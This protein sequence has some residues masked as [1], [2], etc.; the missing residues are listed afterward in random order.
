MRLSDQTVLEIGRGQPPGPG[1]D[2]RRIDLGDA[3]LLPRWVNAHTHLEFSG[4]SAPIGTPGIALSDWIRQVVAARAGESLAARQH[5]VARGI[6]ELRDS[7][8]RLAADIVTPPCTPPPSAAATQRELEVCLLPEVIG[9]SATRSDER[10]AAAVGLMQQYPAAG[11]SPHAPYSTR[12][13]AIQWCVEMARRSGVTLAMHVAESPAERRLLT[14]G[15]GP[16]A[17]VLREMGVWQPDIF[18]WGGRPFH[19]LIDRLAAAPRGLIIHG[20]QLTDA[21]IDRIARHPNLTVV[22]CPRTH[23]FF[24]YQTHPVARLRSAGVRVAL[25]TD[26]RASNPDLNLWGE[27]RF[28]LSRRPDLPPAAVLEMAT[29]AGAQALGYQHVGQ[30]QIGCRPG[31]CTVPTSAATVSRL[32]EDLATVETVVPID[33]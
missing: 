6:E 27:V 18:P 31:F 2:R 32:Y 25:G 8:T 11:I 12:P 1:S 9:L 23:A 29:W 26:S 30:I 10:Q 20:N 22:Y 7:G 19:D 16:L 24:D 4:L 5:A 3:V 14:R 15:D 13:Q 28:L 33:P 21:E 17:A